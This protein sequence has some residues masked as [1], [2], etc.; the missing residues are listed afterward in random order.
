MF[1]QGQWKRNF[2]LRLIEKNTHRG[3]QWDNGLVCW[4]AALNSMENGLTAT[5]QKSMWVVASND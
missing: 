4:K 2:H 1:R 5:P 3:D